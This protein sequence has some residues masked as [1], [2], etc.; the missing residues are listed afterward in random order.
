MPSI[1]DLLSLIPRGIY[2]E[3]QKRV[4]RE[5][6]PVYTWI[7]PVTAPAAI[8]Q[9]YVPTQF[10]ASRKYSP[11]DNLEIVNN[12]PANNL[13]V[14]INGNDE[15][16][17]PAGSIRPIHGNGVALWTIQVRN[18]GAGNTTLGLVVLTF[19][20]EPLSTDKWVQQNA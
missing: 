18:D 15:R 3:R 7:L 10:P 2:D 5:G 9:I 17:V 19:Q 8:S 16:P 4:R 20:K 11:L 1:F 13:T 14:I 6:S 12:E